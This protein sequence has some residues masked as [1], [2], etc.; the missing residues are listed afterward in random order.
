MPSLADATIHGARGDAGRRTEALD[1]F[2]DLIGERAEALEERAVEL[3]AFPRAVVRGDI[4]LAVRRVRELPRLLPE[5][6]GR[7]PLGTVAL[8]LPGNAVL[9][10]PA[11]TIAASYL[12]GNRT[13][14]RLPRRRSAW[15]EV[16][17]DLVRSTLAN[18]VDFS[19]LD[20]ATFISRAMADPG[21]GAV[22]AFG[23]DRWATRYEHGARRTGTRFVFEGPGKDPF[24]VLDDA[25]AEAAAAGAAAA[26]LY[27]GGQACTAPE[28]FYVHADRY[29]EFVEA[30][31][32][33][34]RGL[35]AGDPRD[36]ATQVGPLP[37]SRA[38]HVL[39]QIREA[40]SAGA[41]LLCGGAVRELPGWEDH[42]VLVTP[43]VLVDVDHTMA[44]LREETF[45]P[46]IPVRRVDSAE[47]A[48]ELSEDSSYGLSA[49][50]YGG[51]PSVGA[52]LARTHGEVFANETW[53]ARRR[54]DPLA[55]YGG[56]RQSGWVWEWS[57]DAFIRR[58][59]PRLNLHE[60]S[61]E[62]TTQMTTHTGTEH[63]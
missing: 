53:L 34:A 43:A 31:V 12:A 50:V 47:Q 58:D 3:L 28:R 22:L 62:S 52:R 7:A 27:N 41:R 17:A 51:A 55:R 24:V 45:G 49:T 4:A 5:L 40:V 46:V 44:I 1:A 38:D 23:D 57:G 16:V 48:L 32:E 54:R 21:V 63:A 9:S 10:N 25:S 33:L 19:D 30:V 61:S 6:D 8:C 13:L 42:G 36:E 2:A 39:G 14:V 56:R 35:G 60:F 26:G 59:G 11:A 37:R 18:A 15:A 29:D 20:G